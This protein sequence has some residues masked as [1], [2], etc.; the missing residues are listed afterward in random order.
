MSE[1]TTGDSSVPPANLWN[2]VRT[3]RRI[4][5]FVFATLLLH[6]GLA[7]ETARYCSVTHDEYWHIPV[8]LLNLQT[9]R[10][11]WENLNPPLI[12]MIAAV[13]LTVIA[14]SGSISEPTSDIWSYGDD[15]LRSNAD[16]YQTILLSARIPIILLSLATAWLAGCWA[17]ELFGRNAGL[18]AIFLWCTSPN[19]LAS[20]SLVTTDLG[21]AFFFLLCGRQTWKFA[22]ENSWR[23]AVL[24]GTFLGLA[25][26]AKFTAVL[27]WLLLPV[28][29]V[30]QSRRKSIRRAQ[31]RD[32]FV[33]WAGV[34]AISI[35]VLNAGYLFRGSGTP[36]AEYNFSSQAMRDIQSAAGVLA[37]L[38][39]PAPQDWLEGVDAQRK[40]ME[41]DHPVYLDG[42]WSVTGFGSYYFMVLLYKLPHI[43]QVLFL[44]ALWSVVR[45]ARTSSRLRNSVAVLI[46]A[47]AL[48]GL[49]GFSGMQLGIRYILP[50][51]PFVFV[52]ISQSAE[53]IGRLHWRS[54][55]GVVAVAATLLV[56]SLRFHPHHIAYF[57]EFAGGPENGWI[58]LSDS[59]IDW[60]Q[61]LNGLKLWTEEH[62]E[63]APLNL[64]Y[65]GTV[66]PAELGIEHRLISRTSGPEPGWY[67]ASISLIQGRP[68]PVRRPDSSTVNLGIGELSWLQLFEP[69]D[70]IGHSINIYHLTTA[71]VRRYHAA[72]RELNTPD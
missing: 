23:S 63:A 65:F 8:G 3:D 20:A 69:T 59:N 26:L 32:T 18:A 62:P 52:F 22:K 51:L 7:F 29:W 50:T 5:A 30:I 44:S 27:L 42:Q 56:A 25:Q 16:G 31:L 58:H 57:N 36:L 9:G 39:L 47:V 54:R 41:S 37:T 2:E 12:R 72:V 46:P 66:P 35:V 34:I 24:L 33:K 61:D 15:L 17:T 21:A 48:F 6:A 1:P 60:G 45:Q 55:I 68:T 67:A 11:D 10:F 43:L 64:T 71:D 14:E 13:P 28:V 70:R 53:T 49:A 4:A 19:V 38:P 40:M